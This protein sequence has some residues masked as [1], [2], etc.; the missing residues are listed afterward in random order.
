MVVVTDQNPIEV[1]VRLHVRD[2]LNNLVP[3]VLQG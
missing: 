3:E 1:T 2:A